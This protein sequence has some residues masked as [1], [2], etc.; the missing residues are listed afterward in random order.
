ML[1]VEAEKSAR[2]S[3]A[4]VTPARTE[5]ES[6]SRA[7][8]VHTID[9]SLESLPPRPTIVSEIP[10]P[11]KKEALRAEKDPLFVPGL[12]TRALR[13]STQTYISSITAAI[14]RFEI[15][16]PVV[17]FGATALAVGIFAN[18]IVAPATTLGVIGA[19]AVL[20]SCGFKRNDHARAQ[21]LIA[22][23]FNISHL[24]LIGHY[25]A[26]VSSILGGVR[27]VFQS[28]IPDSR[29][30]ARIGSAIFGA[31][32]GIG[33]FATCTEIFPLARVDNMPMIATTF[34]ALSGAFTAK[35]SGLS[36]LSGL[37]GTL[38]LL[39]YHV[40]RVDI[41]IPA[42]FTGVGLA[43]TI[44]AAICKHDLLPRLQR[45]K[46]GAA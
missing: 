6:P 39:P 23:V 29:I 24:M 34:F 27:G 36:R 21:G 2:L 28:M 41:S 8:A 4:G 1:R 45:R 12:L 44:S 31:A 25:T 15:S 40:S 13:E 16:T 38:S 19:T 20:A 17:K 7:A 14:E 22:T 10:S 37:M 30:N 9:L 35:Y 42:V 11:S 26:T 18:M 5:K 46:D 3:Q 43:L 32:V 33:V